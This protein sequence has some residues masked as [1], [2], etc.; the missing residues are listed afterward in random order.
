MLSR[1]IN[2]LIGIKPIYS[3]M[4]VAAKQ[5]LVDTANKNGIPW[6]ETVRELQSNPEVLAFP[7][8]QTAAPGSL[9]E[10][11]LKEKANLLQVYALKDAVENKAVVYP[12]YYLQPFHA[13]PKGNLDWLPAFEVESATMSMAV[14]TF[15]GTEPEAAQQRL[16]GNMHAAIKVLHSCLTCCRCPQRLT[17]RL[18]QI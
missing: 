17:D 2:T 8:F 10:S 3:V 4:K 7:V 15:P 6:K 16:R 18:A 1:V 9:W 14:R 5:V 11:E 13:Y 12:N